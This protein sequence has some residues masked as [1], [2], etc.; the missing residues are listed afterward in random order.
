MQVDESEKPTQ[1][2][3][4]GESEKSHPKGEEEDSEIEVGKWQTP[5]QTPRESI[6]GSCCISCSPNRFSGGNRFSRSI[7]TPPTSP[8]AFVFKPN[9]TVE[10]DITFAS[11]TTSASIIPETPKKSFSIHLQQ[12]KETFPQNVQETSHQ[13]YR[14]STSSTRRAGTFTSKSKRTIK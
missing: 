14:S 1:I 2:E 7:P 5:P 10:S 6:D 11:T 9:H 8:Q 4:D 13:Y 12:S 3:Q